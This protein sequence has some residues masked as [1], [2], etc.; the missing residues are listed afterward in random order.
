M[1][2][3]PVALRD[4]LKQGLEEMEM[5]GVIDKLDQPTEWVN[6]VV[7]VEK[8]GSKK[9]LICHDPRPLNE[10]ILREHYKMPTIEEITT[11][12]AG[13]TVFSK[14][15]ANHGYWQVPLDVE[16]QLLTTFNGVETGHNC[17]I[18]HKLTAQAGG[19][20]GGGGGETR[21]VES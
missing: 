16:S 19:G 18:G 20:G 2:S 9:L 15:D 14:L 10:A 13:A 17:T 8:P 6:S 7:V 12:V 1:K 4:R 3:Q 5:D 21:R 11:R